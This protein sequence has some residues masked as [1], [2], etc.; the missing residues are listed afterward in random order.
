MRVWVAPP[1]CELHPPRADETRAIAAAG[2]GIL[3]SENVS[4]MLGLLHVGG[5]W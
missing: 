3:L 1:A 5:S 4:L 2:V